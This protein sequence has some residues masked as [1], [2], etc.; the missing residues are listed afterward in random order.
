MARSRPRRG[1]GGHVRGDLAECFAPR[2]PG[3]PAEDSPRALRPR[4]RRDGGDGTMTGRS[5]LKQPGVPSKE[6]AAEHARRIAKTRAAYASMSRRG[7]ALHGALR[8][9]SAASDRSAPRDSARGRHFSFSENARDTRDDSEDAPPGGSSAFAFATG[10]TNGHAKSERASG[11]SGAGA[12]I[13]T[14][15]KKRETRLEPSVDVLAALAYARGAEPAPPRTSAAA[16]D[17]DDSDDSDDDG[18]TRASPPM[19]N[20]R[21]LSSP[22]DPLTPSRA[23]FA[24]SAL[25]R[26]RADSD[27]SDLA[28]EAEEATRRRFRAV[29]EFE[30][31]A[32]AKRAR[33]AARAA[34]N[35]ANA[36]A[37]G[38]ETAV[39]NMRAE[40]EASVSASRSDASDERDET[41]NA[42]ANE[43]RRARAPSLAPSPPPPTPRAPRGVT[44]DSKVR[45][46]Q[47]PFHAFA[48]AAARTRTR[49]RDE[50]EPKKG[51][52]YS[53]SAALV[54]AR[55][56]LAGAAAAAAE[57]TKAA[58][59]TPPTAR[60]WE[61]VSAHSET[62]GASA[63]ASAS[64]RRRVGSRETAK[65]VSL[66]DGEPPTGDD[67]SGESP[68]RKDPTSVDAGTGAEA[69]EAPSAVA[70]QI[71]VA[72]DFSA[73]TRRVM[74]AGRA[75]RAELLAAYQALAARCR[76]VASASSLAETRENGAEAP[77]RANDAND[78]TLHVASN[79][80]MTKTKPHTTETADTPNN[81]NRP[82][83]VPSRDDTLRLIRDMEDRARRTFATN[84]NPPRTELKSAVELKSAATAQTA[85]AGVPRGLR[86]FARRPPALPVPT[87][88]LSSDS[89]A[90]DS[91]DSA[92][93]TPPP[94]EKNDAARFFLSEEE[95]ED[96]AR[97]ESEG[98]GPRDPR[99]PRDPR[100]GLDVPPGVEPELRVSDVR[101][102][103]SLVA[104][105]FQ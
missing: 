45:T 51:A 43:R 26:S 80:V 34:A 63:S 65:P 55:D 60:R 37:A 68:F 29:A 36:A 77:M 35:A 24:R 67:G 64:P 19:G 41:R 92:G 25:A 78:E 53:A 90:F 87:P 99:D 102:F 33:A 38:A 11:A 13:R 72:L 48:N 52:S 101:D 16:R 58:A 71:S 27:A 94:R 9:G 56:A 104:Y 6:T 97:E 89:C 10:R 12:Y 100:L 7:G 91:D 4:R 8:P 18:V 95:K 17:S 44:A 40:M 79:R 75:R 105:A 59:R 47:D 83:V 30:A 28:D 46:P 74:D 14:R 5:P 61:H 82:F 81:M 98:K 70:S 15:A 84:P 86:A 66:R 22:D 73:A 88:T 21:S 31:A 85:F 20:L 93:L 62:S 69:A 96:P 39:A 49:P 54:A 50:N 2:A 1:L 23:W 3:W 103:E 32:R 57:L 76:D 42:D